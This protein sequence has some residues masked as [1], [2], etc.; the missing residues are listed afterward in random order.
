MTYTH[1]N[2][3]RQTH[4]QPRAHTFQ[5]RRNTNAYTQ[6]Q[7]GTQCH[8]NTY[9]R[10]PHFKFDDHTQ[11]HAYN[12]NFA[13]D[14][15]TYTLPRPSA[16]YH[17]TMPSD[18]YNNYIPQ[19]PEHIYDQYHPYMQYIPTPLGGLGIGIAQRDKVPPSGD[20]QQH[21]KELQQ[22]MASMQTPIKNY[23]IH[24]IC[25]YPFDRSKPMPPFP[26]HFVVPKFDKY[27]GKGD[28]KAHTREFFTTFIELAQE[29][30]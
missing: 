16:P 11:D 20:L 21:I 23:T 26:P 30:S 4:E 17:N 12:T 29:D 13:H 9:T 15:D 3:A 2:D 7:V 22:Q 14:Y 18:S 6:Q 27:K 25:P 5:G 1:T 19:P 28:P 8:D 24:K 10:R